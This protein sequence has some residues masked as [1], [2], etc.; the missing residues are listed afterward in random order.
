MWTDW[1]HNP[2]NESLVDS[3]EVSMFYV[4]W[5]IALC[6]SCLKGLVLMMC[7]D[8]DEWM[9]EWMFLI[10]AWSP[11]TART[12][13]TTQK[14]R[15]VD[16]AVQCYVNVVRASCK[17]EQKARPSVYCRKLTVTAMLKLTPAD[18]SKQMQQHYCDLLRW[19]SHFKTDTIT[20]L[21]H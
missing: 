17:T 8:D 10:V 11:K 3:I 2:A 6:A 15:T 7:D 1:R 18:C 19:C 14:S 12:Q 13:N 4:S 9:N 20:Q 21:N 5:W 16:S